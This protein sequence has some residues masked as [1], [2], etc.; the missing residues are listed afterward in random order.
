[1]AA[2]SKS[3]HPF[4]CSLARALANARLP[5]R[6]HGVSHVFIRRSVAADERRRDYELREE[7]RERNKG[8]TVRE[9]VVYSCDELRR[10][11]DLPSSTENL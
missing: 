8:G 11:S 5:G 4:S 9:W 1:M 3:S 7:A 2:L 10:A 6:R